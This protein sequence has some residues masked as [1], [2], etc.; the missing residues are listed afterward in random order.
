[1]KQLL[2][3]SGS[4]FVQANEL[5][6]SPADLSGS[7]LLLET[8]FDQWMDER[9]ELSASQHTQIADMDP[10]FKAT[11]AEAIARELLAGRTIAFAKASKTE[12][13]RDKDVYIFSSTQQSYSFDSA[14]MR[15]DEGLQILIT[16]R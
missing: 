8:D 7:M 15:R 3:A 10:T 16:Y 6:Q 13:L 12:K 14:S 5:A 2:N 9:F 4:A 1:M 11:L